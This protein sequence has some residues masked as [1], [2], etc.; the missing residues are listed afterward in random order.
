MYP[1]LSSSTE[2]PNP[3]AEET[4]L[5]WSGGFDSTFRL[6]SLVLREKRAVQPF[7]L[8]EHQRRSTLHELA[9]MDVIRRKLGARSPEAAGLLR[10]TRVFLVSEIAPHPE[11]THRFQALARRF[12]VGP[13]FEWLPRFA[14]QHG[15]TDLELS[16][17]KNALRPREP[18]FAYLGEFLERDAD[19][20]RLR[21]PL[22]DPDMLIF[23][24]FRYPVY[25]LTKLEM[26][27][28]AGEAGF[29]DLLLD[30]WFCHRPRA[31]RP[32]GTC[33]P[34]VDAMEEGFSFRLPRPARFRYR[35]NR[36]WRRAKAVIPAQRFLRQI[37]A[38]P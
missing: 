35:M 15:C 14:A 24:P 32:C 4:R 22:A 10:P 37:R 38:R 12:R 8:L 2:V 19:G 21:S 7:Y 6:L 34:C 26:L 3:E 9:A 27:R 18:V 36:I 1:T 25:D 31:G 13:Q 23:Q 16:I 20:A 28:Q 17:E 33:H 30:S 11:I 5:L 29:R